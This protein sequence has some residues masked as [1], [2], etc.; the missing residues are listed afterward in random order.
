MSPWAA[1]DGGLQP[2]GQPRREVSKR[3]VQCPVAASWAL[4]SVSAQRKSSS[5]TRKPSKGKQEE[6][7]PSLRLRGNPPHLA[8]TPRPRMAL[9]NR[10]QGIP[11][12][13]GSRGQHKDR[14]LGV[15]SSA[16]QPRLGEFSVSAGC[17]L[18]RLKALS[19]VHWGPGAAKRRGGRVQPDL[20]LAVTQTMAPWTS[21]PTQHQPMREGERLS[22]TPQ[23]AQLAGLPPGGISPLFRGWDSSGEQLLARTPSP[24]WSCTKDA[25]G[26]SGFSLA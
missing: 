19:S 24:P 18:W 1:A 10:P 2:L 11:L 14:E 7:L 3:A 13:P 22:P 16:P 23:G 26:P 20:V 6:I 9:E 25:F 17:G 21:H 5:N 15:R 4:G 8:L 12:P